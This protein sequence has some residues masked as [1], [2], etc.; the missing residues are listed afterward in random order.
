MRFPG[1][2]VQPDGLEALNVG[3]S[4]KIQSLEQSF[5]AKLDDFQQAADRRHQ[6]VL[7]TISQMSTSFESLRQLFDRQSA[8]TTQILTVSESL[9]QMST[10]LSS[11]E[12]SLENVLL[13]RMQG[14]QQSLI[15]EIQKQ[16]S[17]LKISHISVSL[18]AL[19]G[20]FEEQSS[21]ISHIPS[22]LDLVQ[23]LQGQIERLH[24]LTSQRL[25]AVSTDGQPSLDALLRTRDQRMAN[26]TAAINDYQQSE[27]VL[28][29]ATQENDR[30]SQE[31]HRDLMMSA[32]TIAPERQQHDT[33][34]IAQP[35]MVIEASSSDN[36]NQPGE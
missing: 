21:L 30:R 24:A 9:L 29:E 11:K 12:S 17:L 10:E 23:R 16:H 4:G 26:A 31:L 5:A 36:A 7:S 14:L 33:R 13:E 6:Q 34:A 20:K 25:P 18:E 35:D 2:S 3:L 22:L 32:F 19:Q 1:K 27:K 15:D 28:Q 8:A